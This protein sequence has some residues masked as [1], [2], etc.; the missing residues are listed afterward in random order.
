MILFQC[1]GNLFEDHARFLNQK[2]QVPFA[3]E[4]GTIKFDLFFQRIKLQIL[5][6]GLLVPILQSASLIGEIVKIKAVYNRKESLLLF[7]K[8]EARVPQNVY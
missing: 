2:E 4:L 8:G 1:A 6:S 7:S 5:Q 3:L